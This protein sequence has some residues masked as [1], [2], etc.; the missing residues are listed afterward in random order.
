M[1]TINYSNNWT[2]SGLRPGH[3]I[4]IMDSRKITFSALIEELK[5]RGILHLTFFYTV[6]FWL[7]E[8]PLSRVERTFRC[9]LWCPN[10]DHLPSL[11]VTYRVKNL[12]PNV[13]LRYFGSRRVVISVH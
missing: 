2:R 4:T 1:R 5:R 9:P 8:R 12:L 13:L 7:R 11:K 6:G 10:Q 3:G